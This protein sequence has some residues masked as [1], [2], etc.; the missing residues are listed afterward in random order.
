MKLKLIIV[1]A[2]ICFSCK[3]DLSVD[4]TSVLPFYN[5]E[6]FTPEWISEYDPEYA[7]IHK[8]APFKFI[9]QNGKTL[10]NKDFEGKIYIADFFFTSCPSICPILAKNMGVIQEKY[11][12]DDEVLLLSHSVM[13]WVDTVEKIKAYASQKKAINDKWHLV[14]GNRDSIYDLARTSYF[15]DE[16]FKRTGDKD[17]FIHTENFILVDKKGRIRGV[18]NGTLATES[19]RLIQQIEKLKMEG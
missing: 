7:N 6:D 10:T 17:E 5:T 3:K 14:T 12:A 19:K 15:A 4:K 13:P 9:N 2:C 11:K 18:Y 8:V 16:D 1:L